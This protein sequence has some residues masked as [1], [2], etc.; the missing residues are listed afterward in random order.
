MLHTNLEFW[1][2]LIAS[3]DHTENFGGF[4]HGRKNT[5]TSLCMALTETSVSSLR[6]ASSTLT[7]SCSSF[8]PGSGAPLKVGVPMER[9]RRGLCSTGFCP[10][11]IKSYS[12]S[13]ER[14]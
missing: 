10:Y 8:W 5:C 4:Q 2:L 14:L 7:I 11:F 1:T 6:S 13:N 9:A 12:F 3:G